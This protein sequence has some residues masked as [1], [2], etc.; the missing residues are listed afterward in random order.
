MGEHLLELNALPESGAPDGEMTRT[1]KGMLELH[2]GRYRMASQVMTHLAVSGEAA[3]AD[4]SRPAIE[5]F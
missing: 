1:F 4:H 2:K 3:G 5:L